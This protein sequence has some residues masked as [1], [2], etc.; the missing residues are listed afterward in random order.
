MMA[1]IVALLSA[2]NLVPAERVTPPPIERRGDCTV[3]VNEMRRQG[4][5]EAV[6]VKFG[7]IAKRESNCYPVYVH[8][9]DDWSY[10]RYGLNGITPTLRAYWHDL[11]GADVRADTVRLSL[12]TQCAL[13]AYHRSGWRPWAYA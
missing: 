1:L 5:P 12:D 9:H 4:A 11:C 10:S 7:T 13:A 2:L 3:V 8:D 6:A